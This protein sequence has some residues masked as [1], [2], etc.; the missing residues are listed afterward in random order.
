MGNENTNY[1][2]PSYYP[3]GVI[4]SVVQQSSLQNQ[5]SIRLNKP[6]YFK[7]DNL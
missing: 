1:I 3:Q 7:G 6:D 4:Q 5:M 2:G